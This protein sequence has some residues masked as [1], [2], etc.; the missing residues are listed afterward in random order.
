MTEVVDTTSA[1]TIA[2]LTGPQRALVLTGRGL[3]YRPYTLKTKQRLEMT[4]YPGNPVATATVLGA[5]EEPTTIQGAWKDKFIGAQGSNYVTFAG[6]PV[7]NVRDLAEIVDELVRSGRLLEVTWDLTTRHGHLTSFE[8][9]WST[10]RDLEWS[11]TFEWVSR[12]DAISP[13]VVVIDASLG[14]SVGTLRELNTDLQAAAEAPF[15]T[16]PNFQQLLQGYLET[17]DS[18]VNELFDTASNLARAALSPL[19]AVRRA[20]S[21]ANNLIFTCN[22]FFAFLKS[23]ASA[24]YNLS[25]GIGELLFQ[26]KLIAE[27]Y[28]RTLLNRARDLRDAAVAQ[29]AVLTK[30]LRDEL[31]G[32]YVTRDGEDLR[33]IA[34]RYYGSPFEWRR[35][36][37]FNNLQTSALRRG[38]TLMIPKFTTGAAV[39]AC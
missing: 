26:D 33:D 18:Y 8:K 36:M 11:M 28:V 31:I 21:T 32:T 22:D 7:L 35:I 13:V 2:E 39:R 38:Q 12:G 37:E 34:D 5:A 16:S 10:T 9:S 25:A 24:Y 19:D 1:F 20:V 15:A 23:E 17:F 3:P 29:R 14:D 6:S 4:W 27:I 30:Q